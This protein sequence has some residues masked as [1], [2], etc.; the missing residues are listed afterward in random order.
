MLNIRFTVSKDHKSKEQHVEN[1]ER[2]TVP[3]EFLS[4]NEP[5][6]SLIV[7][8]KERNS[9]DIINLII[10]CHSRSLINSF[11]FKNMILKCF[12]CGSKNI[13]DDNCIECNSDNIYWYINGDTY[14]TAKSYGAIIECISIL[15]S[16]LEATLEGKKFQYCL[17]RPPGHHCFNKARGFCLINNIFILS[18]YAI[19]MGYKRVLILD[20]D[21]HHADGT[22]N[23]IR[24]KKDRYLISIHAYSENPLF[25][26]FPGTGSVLENRENIKNIPLIHSNYSDFIKYNDEY[27]FNLIREKALP[28]IE[29]FNPDIILISN[30]L[31]GHKDDPIGNLNLTGQF[32][33]NVTTLLKQ[34]N[35]PLI[36]VLEGG[37]NPEVVKDVS[38]CI[39]DEL[40]N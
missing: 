24:G 13:R 31:D 14:V 27:C 21:Y 40:L 23:L 37:Y 38:K 8:V 2:I 33:V 35:I 32:Y 12:D 17:V 16:S 18:Q 5:Y 25:P 10:K 9:N 36:Y 39:I 19:D 4:N 6:K 30:G 7:K 3:M 29:E 28:W 26:I 22:A 11:S 15:M 1:Q 20:Y 34:L